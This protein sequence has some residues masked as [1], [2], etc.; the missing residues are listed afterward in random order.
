MLLDY[1]LVDSAIEGDI[2]AT[3]DN[4]TFMQ[5]FQKGKVVEDN[6]FLS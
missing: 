2:F 5:R 3:V 4:E 1:T 6:G